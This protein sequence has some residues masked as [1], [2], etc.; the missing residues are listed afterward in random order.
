MSARAM[1]PGE[2][3]PSARQT[4]KHEDR[5]DISDGGKRADQE[6]QRRKLALKPPAHA[7]T[8]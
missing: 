2:S 5:S 6:T 1:Q 7:R 3:S 8:Q 4:A